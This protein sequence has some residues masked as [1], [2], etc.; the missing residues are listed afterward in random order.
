MFLIVKRALATV[1]MCGLAVVGCA[2]EVAGHGSMASIATAPTTLGGDW[3]HTLVA[4]TT[5]R[6]SLS[7]TS[8]VISATGAP[9]C[10][11][12]PPGVHE[13]K[14]MSWPTADEFP[15]AVGLDPYDDIAV[16]VLRMNVNTDRVN[17]GELQTSNDE[18]VA[19]KLG[20]DYTFD[21]PIGDRLMIDNARALHY[22]AKYKKTASTVDF[23]F[24][25]RGTAE[26]ER[27]AI[28]VSTSKLPR[29]ISA[30]SDSSG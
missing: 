3:P 21:S 29:P 27:L 5:P 7:C 11:A 24:V 22:R 4:A 8:R 6:R 19:R 15:T 28:P 18:G 30:P 14:N 12:L 9:Y 23:Y 17:N 16:A 2:T 1:A 26:L 20:G 13:I 10:Y 25:F